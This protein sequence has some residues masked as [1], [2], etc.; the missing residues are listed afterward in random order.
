MPGPEPALVARDEALLVHV[1][2]QLPDSFAAQLPAGSTAARRLARAYGVDDRLTEGRAE[3][4]VPERA[5]LAEIVEDLGAG[6]PASA[7]RG[8]DSV[9]A[10]HRIAIVTNVP[11]HYRL[12]L[13]AALEGRLREAGAELRVFFA[14][15]APA[16]RPWMRHEQLDFTHEF[17]PSVE[18]RLGERS[19]YVPR[20]LGRRLAGFA[21]TIVLVG[22]FSPAVAGQAA[23]YARR[24]G[25]ALGVWSGEIGG[26][27]SARGRLRRVQR[28][29]VVAPARFG[30]AYGSASREYLSALAPRLPIVIGRNT[31]VA[32]AD[33][34]VPT[35]TQPVSL[36][37]VAHLVPRKGI[38]VLLEALR[39]RPDLACRLTVV[40]D[41]PERARLESLA[42]GDARIAFAGALA[43][44]RVSAEY[45]RADVFLFPTHADV[46]GLVL[47]EAMAA[48]LATA[49][50]RAAGAAADLCVDGVNALVV[51]DH[52]P[53]S[54]AAAVARLVGDHELRARL[55]RRAAATVAARWT[56]AHAVDAMVA[57]LR[58]GAA[59]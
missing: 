30:I 10:G 16:S 39:L 45:R 27:S 26:M 54:W 19:R 12:P 2:A 9:L 17:V 40:G 23:L 56:L 59:S 5:T 53:E 33:A 11:A 29:L 34:V 46:F 18:V 44:D 14:S 58:L 20:R 50:S 21:P 7:R 28:R 48:G 52:A 57:G 41:G 4:L 38:D 1:L 49:V 25:V 43:P 47:V 37:T 15:A 22:G 24:R 36:L 55:R 35:S 32:A 51:P 13:F 31:S 42:A 6:E 3:Q 8:D